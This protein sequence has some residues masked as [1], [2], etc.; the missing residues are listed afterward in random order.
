[1]GNVTHQVHDQSPAGHR[2]NQT[3]VTAMGTTENCHQ[4]PQRR[5]AGQKKRKKRKEREWEREK[6]EAKKMR[7]TTP[8]TRTEIP[9]EAAK[10]SRAP[11]VAATVA[12]A[13]VETHAG[14][15]PAENE[16]KERKRRKRK[17]KKK[18]RNKKKKRG[19]KKEQKRMNGRA[20]K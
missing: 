9:Q 5:T 12:K 10:C 15:R 13:I 20:N 19:K 16:K 8:N 14:R 3:L 2:P 17:R 4:K 7:S 6:E 18:E 11:K 1:M